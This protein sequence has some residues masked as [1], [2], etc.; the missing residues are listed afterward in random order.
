MSQP[1]IL[2]RDGREYQ[3]PD[4]ETLR[5]WAQDGR[6]MPADMVYSPV[7][8]SWYRAHDL[9]G[10]RDVLPKPDA[11]AP[12]QVSPPAQTQ[13]AA[14]HQKFWLR[15]GDQN[16]PADSL[17]VILQWA[18]KGNIHPDDYIYH[19]G[20]GKWF[21]AGDSPQLVSRFPAPLQAPVARG[22]MP[23]DPGPGVSRS[24]MPIHESGGRP[25]LSTSASG[26]SLGGAGLSPTRPKS[27]N[28]EPAD[29]MAK[30]MVDFQAIVIDK[31]AK[32]GAAG[33]KVS[34]LADA[35]SRLGHKSSR[36][37]DDDQ[38]RRPTL[39]PN[40][41]ADMPSTRAGDGDLGHIESRQT[42]DVTPGSIERARSA[43]SATR[44]TT[45]ARAL[46]RSS[47]I[48]RSGAGVV[49]P[50]KSGAGVVRSSSKTGGHVV[51]PRPTAPPSD[52]LEVVAD[53][54]PAAEAPVVDAPVEAP[55]PA[56]PTI[57][58]E[59]SPVSEAVGPPEA[60]PVEVVAVAAEPEVAAETAAAAEVSSAAAD[61]APADIDP[62]AKFTDR[63]GLMR[64]FYDF[65][66]VFV[67]TRDLR[68]GELLESSCK[69]PSLEN[70]DL[71]GTAKRAVFAQIQAMVDKHVA[72]VVDPIRSELTA[73]E[74]PG[75][76]NLRGRCYELM[77]ALRVAEP[78]IGVKPPE[79]VVIGNQGRPKMSSEEQGSML[80]IDHAIKGV[81]SV[82]AKQKAA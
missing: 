18:S 62:D 57:E 13:P 78:Y 31:A 23:Q 67:V 4:L 33:G 35:A 8:Q 25:S 47:T 44:S 17:D 14:S 60:A 52:E 64:V 22:P 74:L 59:P 48:D 72:D 49:R 66:R 37:A 6:V 61:A 75:Y 54:V 36:S 70:R 20:Y 81:I 1:Y 51:I 9:R 56:P 76:E 58:R 15:K 40:T 12:P 77:E 42:V 82:R 21:R 3:A 63:F 79:R 27:K 32:A 41:I 50:M 80:R 30:T 46:R 53:E 43:E 16:Y 73:D 19:P 24:S 45:G 10:L 29:S 28:L 55:T 65:A 38:P 5:R 69:V 68:P 11:G 39:S 34:S 71:M 26:A 2:R 7:Y